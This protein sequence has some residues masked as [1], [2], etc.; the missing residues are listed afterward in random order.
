MVESKK[1]NNPGNTT[2]RYHGLDLARAFLMISVLLYHSS[3]IFS[4]EGNW[5]VSYFEQEFSFKILATILDF[6]IMPAF[7]ILSGFFFY[8]V[9]SR[10]GFKNAFKSRFVRLFI[11]LIFI[12]FTL[13]TTMNWIAPASDTNH[14][15][16]DPLGYIFFGKWLGH[17]WFL[18]N[19]IIYNALSFLFIWAI[20]RLKFLKLE[21]WNKALLMSLIALFIPILFMACVFIA[22]QTYKD[23][24]LFISFF[25]LFKNLP[26]YLLGLFFFRYKDLFFWALK[27]KIF[28]PWV[29][30]AITA[31][32]V[33]IQK[34]D[35]VIIYNYFYATLVFSLSI[36]VIGIMNKVGNKENAAVKTFSN[37]SY[38][39]YLLHQPILIMIFPLFIILSMSSY[40][41]FITIV[42]I[43]F[44]TTFFFHQYC[45]KNSKILSLLMNG[46][47][48]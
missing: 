23:N 37:A 14:L 32:L 11:P 21:Q 1:Y 36:T 42:A 47:Y 2:E 33:V 3:L 5:R 30:F 24:F 44:L 7:F 25:N 10:D 34:Y 8:L 18:G 13:N 48:K 46:V 27:P 39:I 43:V 17:L 26:Y 28:L 45:V 20:D 38:S 22:L 9:Y 6:Y 31:Y 16:D 35:A 19:L 15:S 4:T 12:G 40:L 41:S 29:A